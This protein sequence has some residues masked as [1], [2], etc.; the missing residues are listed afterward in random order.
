[1]TG[2][3]LSTHLALLWVFIEATTLTSAPFIT[4]DRS[5]RSLEALWK[6]VFICSIGIALSFVG[7]ILLSMGAGHLDS[8]FFSDL[9]RNAR[10]IDPFWLKTAFLFLVIGFGTKAGLAPVHAWLPDAH[11]E[12][13]SP[14]S[15]MLSGTLLNAALLGIARVFKLMTLAGAGSEARTILVVMGF[16]SLFVSAVFMLKSVNYKR[17]LAYS[18]I[19]NMG[20]AAIGISAGGIGAFAAML[21][22]ASH[23]LTKASF[24]LTSGNIYHRHHTKDI[25]S[26]QGL[27]KSD[28]VTGWLWIACFLGIA[29]FPPF[30]SFFSELLVAQSLLKQGSA[31]LA[32]LYLVLLAVIVYGM[33][34]AVFRMSFGSGS[35]EPEGR[36]HV[37]EYAPQ[38]VFLLILVFSVIYPSG[39]VLRLIRNAASAL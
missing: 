13:P 22:I 37:L 31:G 39:A 8:L 2:V 12:A 16:L 34:R 15:A 28:A 11:S 33:G 5:R 38:I 9:C 4:F 27:L 23:S 21:H 29:G 3:L 1:M 35:R 32:A 14:V 25:G 24:F 17:M 19:E 30:P 10:S 36:L 18:S 20:I 6:Y 7:I 26:V